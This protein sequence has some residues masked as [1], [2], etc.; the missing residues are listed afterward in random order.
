MSLSWT[1]VVRTR[2]PSAHSDRPSRTRCVRWHFSGRNE[3]GRVVITRRSTVPPGWCQPKGW[4]KA[5]LVV[6][7]SMHLMA[8]PYE[9][10]AL[11][12]TAYPPEEDVRLYGGESWVEVDAA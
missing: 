5:N 6:P 11:G 9:A 1:S 7:E 12:Q 4:K 8:C 3:G 2:I 10:R